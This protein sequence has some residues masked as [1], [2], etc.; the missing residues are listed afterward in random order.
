MGYGGHTHTRVH[1]LILSNLINHTKNGERTEH[2]R[3]RHDAVKPKNPGSRLLVKTQA[4]C[5]GLAVGP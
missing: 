1:V 5:G 3:A 2:G 4:T